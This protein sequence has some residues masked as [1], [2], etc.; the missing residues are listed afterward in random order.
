MADQPADNR[1]SHAAQCG[2]GG[3]VFADIGTRRIEGRGGELAPVLPPKLPD[4]G[5][6]AVK[7]ASGDSSGN[8]AVMAKVDDE[9]ELRQALDEMKERYA[10]YM[11]S[12]APELAPMKRRK[13]LKQFLYRRQAREDREAFQRV[14]EGHGDWEEA[15]IPH[16]GGPLGQAVVYYRTTFEIT[17]SELEIGSIF[18]RFKGVD[19]KALVFVNGTCLGSHE[20]FFA[21]FEF[22]CTDHVRLGDNVLVVQVENDFTFGSSETEEAPGERF[23]GDK[24]YAAT[25]PGYDDPQ[26][27]W[28]HCPPGMG[29]YQDVYVEARPTVHIGDIFVRPMPEQESAEAWIEVFSRDRAA[30]NIRLELAVHGYNFAEETVAW[31]SWQPES[32]VEV[33]LGDTFTKAKVKGDGTYRQPIKLLVAKGVNYFK[34]PLQLKQPRLWEPDTPWL[35]QL[36]A[37]LLDDR[38]DVRDTES[39]TFGMRSFRQDMESEPKGKFYLNDREIRLRGANTMGHEQQCVMKEDWEQLLEDLLLA[40]LAN[41]NFLRLTQRPVQEEV[42]DYCDRLGLMTQTDLPLFGVLRRNKFVE[43]VRQAE[44]MERLIRPHPCNI[45][46]SY[47]NEPFPNAANKP[48]RHLDRQELE[49]FFDAADIAVKLHNPDRV[50]KHV[51]GDYDPPSSSLPDYHCYSCWYNGHGMDIGLLHKGGWLPVREG[52]HYGCGEFGAEGLD[53]AEVMTAHYPPDWL[54]AS[55]KEERWSPNAII[56][57]QTGRFHYFFYETPKGLEHWV[58]A[59]HRYQAWATRIMTEAFRRDS[60]MNTFAIHLFIDAFP[61][62]WMKTIMDV[63][64]RPKPAYFAYRE[65]LSPLAVQLRSDRFAYW[66]DEGMKVEA[67]ICND[68]QLDY[69]GARLRYR[70]EAGGEVLACGS[71][72]ADI[73]L[74]DSRFQGYIETPP[75]HVS[76]RTTAVLRLQLADASGEP[77]HETTFEA[78]VWPK[79]REGADAATGYKDNRDNE[80]RRVAVVDNA[81]G[82]LP[83]W[84]RELGAVVPIELEEAGV[85][86]VICIRSLEA[87][88]EQKAE[89]LSLAESGATLLF[90]ELP[91]GRWDLLGDTVDVRPCGMMPVHFVSRDTGHPL[92]DFAGT[93]D[94]RLWYHER[95]ER[96]V[97][98]LGTTFT[99]GGWQ[100]VLTSGNRN[101][102]GEWA[103]ALAVAGRK[104]GRG[105][106]WISQ[107]EL[108]GR[109]RHNPSAWLLANGLLTGA[110]R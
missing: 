23:E 40:K 93:E 48:H 41:M 57:A 49:R 79:E 99:A 10:P 82:K 34:V 56:G 71:H 89:V 68:T 4:I 70:L 86:D 66:S 101:D 7:E 33:G 17:Q 83:D 27:G 1:L 102:E 37:K 5:L 97:P 24:L 104:I 11:R 19:Y 75:L 65:A 69:P 80:G 60:R 85:G 25:G 46:V 103:P 95:E 43:A 100:P 105:Q 73:P 6:S 47:I 90:L 28:H 13:K 76:K 55:G 53:Y 92:V 91:P 64:R 42:Y 16:Y 81:G 29:I 94:F 58:A 54:P 87:Y 78:A 18:V 67:W 84:M 107:L 88:Q 15:Q 35:Y 21:P 39:R 32:V 2:G 110:D 62:G 14:L 38:E 63:N 22:D 108:D 8:W 30:L 61:S 74:C 106:A 72:E 59:S 52:W 20:G 51:D 3:D 77:L 96:I 26:Y 50:I 44:E 109:V 45:L 9:L 36:Q 98:L 31:H 12:L